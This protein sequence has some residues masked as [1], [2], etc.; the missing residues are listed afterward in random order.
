MLSWKCHISIHV[1]IQKTP[2]FTSLNQYIYAMVT[3]K[4]HIVF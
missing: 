3:N 4:I 1:E 2:Y